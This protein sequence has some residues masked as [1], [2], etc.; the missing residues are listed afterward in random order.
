MAE[1][2]KDT[3]TDIPSEWL[4]AQTKPPRETQTHI[5]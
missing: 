4:P 1:T 5:F 2:I 3:K